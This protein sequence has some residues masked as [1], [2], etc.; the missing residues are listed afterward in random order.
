MTCGRCDNELMLPPLQRGRTVQA[1]CRTCHAPLS[2]KIGNVLVERLTGG[3][4]VVGGGDDD[5]DELEA[6]LK[7]VR[8]KSHDQFR[9]LG[10]I[11]GKPLPNKGACKHYQQ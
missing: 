10:L 9:Q 11:V 7:K 3:G 2:A 5:D 8:K 6:L 1:G 4:R